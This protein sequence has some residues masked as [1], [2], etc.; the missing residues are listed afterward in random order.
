MHLYAGHGEIRDLKLDGDRRLSLHLVLLHARQTE[1]CAHQKLLSTLST[2]TRAQSSYRTHNVSGQMLSV[3]LGSYWEGFNAP[4]HQV[5]LREVF[6][7]TR[8]GFEL[9]RV[10]V[11]RHRHVDLHVI[12][13]RLLFKLPFSLE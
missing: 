7:V 5:L 11:A 3:Y 12:G 13:Y 1:V 9:G 2:N 8:A 6:S 4:H 10:G